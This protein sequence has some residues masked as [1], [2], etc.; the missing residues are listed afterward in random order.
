MLRYTDLECREFNTT[1][2]H[3]LERFDTF[4][5][6][7]EGTGCLLFFQMYPWKYMT[8][9]MTIINYLPET[10]DIVIQYKLDGGNIRIMD[11]FNRERNDN[12]FGEYFDVGVYQTKY[13][14]TVALCAVP[15]DLRAVKLMLE[16][17]REPIYDSFL[18]TAEAT[19]QC[20]R[21]RLPEELI[22]IIINIFIKISN[23]FI[24]SDDILWYHDYQM[25]FT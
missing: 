13:S 18:K 15:N 2:F 5:F 6:R 16:A 20:L 17:M 4:Y 14:V 11:F 8:Y 9:N 1:D 22:D 21:G 23:P 10:I 12:H 25:K 7:L 3:Y 24:D 19:K